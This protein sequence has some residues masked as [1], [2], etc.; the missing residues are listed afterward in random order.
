VPEATQCSHCLRFGAFEVDLRAGELRKQGLKV[1]LQ[2]RPLQI[3]ALL[4]ENPGEVVTREE[5]RQ[6]LWPADTFVDFDHSVNTAINKLRE[7][8]GDS[9]ESPRFIE[10]LPRHGYRFIGHVEPVRAIRTPQ[11]VEA[12][13][14]APAESGL[15]LV[16]EQSP[17]VPAPV[18]AEHPPMAV[19]DGR[20]RRRRLPIVAVGGLAAV[21]VFGALFAL[22]VASLRSRLLSSA[23]AGHGTPLPKIESIAVLPFENLS[24]DPK[25]EYFADG[26]TDELITT[27]GQISA[28]RVISRQSVMRYKGSKKPLPE[29]GRE[30]HVDAVL[31]AAVRRS[32]DRVRITVQLVRTNPERQVWAQTY[33]RDLGDVLALQSEVARAIASQIRIR[34]T[35]QENVRLAGSRP[36]NPE[37]YRLYLQGRYYF[38]K[39]TLPAFHKSI[40]LFQQALEKDPNSALAYAGLSESYA[41]LPFYGVA[42]PREAFPKARAAALKALELDNTLAEAHAALGNVLFYYDWD[43]PAAESEL[44]R[45]IELNPNYAVAHHWYSEYLSAMGRHEQAIA[46]A[47]RAQEI[48]PVSPLMVAIECEADFN[49]RRDDEAIKQCRKALDLDPNLGLA[50]N[51]LGWAYLRKGMYEE[52]MAQFEE[53]NRLVGGDPVLGRARVYAAVGRRGEAVKMLD[54]F[55]EQCKRG[56][57]SPMYLAFLYVALGKKQKALDWLEKAYKGRDPYILRIRVWS[58]LD[59]IRS[60]PRFQDLMRRMNFPP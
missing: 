35:P 1:K 8:L 48:D 49:A 53:G 20:E 38:F 22:N 28:L 5:L 59:P 36:V 54:R 39:R 7:S 16:P 30:L 45:A 56:E 24:D 26:M 3:L 14:S 58:A 31:E 2:E 33:Q 47:R 32:G 41:V 15:S 10:T 12:F 21:V 19:K 51:I 18:V 46:E 52:A 37:A 4:L 34:L 55:S 13:H 11:A 27:L 44:K 57:V 9:A 42:L 60:D 50:H 17:A 29:I 6:Q 43:W 23:G 25:Q 40:Q